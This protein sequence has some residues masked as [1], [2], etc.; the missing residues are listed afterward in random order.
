MKRTGQF[1]VL[2]AAL[3]LQMGFANGAWAVDT[4]DI[5][6][7]R[8]AQARARSL[9]RELIT[10]VLDIQLRQLEENNLQTLP[11]YKDIKEM[12]TNID[13]VEAA[14]MQRVVDALIRVQEQTDP[15]KRLE[16]FNEAREEIRV[17][18]RDLIAERQKLLRRLQVARLAA[19]VRELIRREEGILGST[20]ETTSLPK[21]E[22]ER[23][24]LAT[25]ADQKDMRVLYLELVNTIGDMKNWGGQLT[26]AAIRAEEILDIGRVDERPVE[27]EIN[28][29]IAALE[30]ARVEDA[31]AGEKL[32]IERLERLLEDIEKTQG[33]I[34]ADREEAIKM[35]EE[36]IE[37]QQ[38]LR[39]ETQ[40]SELTDEQIEALSDKQLDVH[41]QIGQIAQSLEEIDA[42]QPLL[43]EAKASALDARDELFEGDQEAADREQG[44]VLGA[45]NEAAEQLEKLI[46]QEEGGKSADAL[47]ED[48]EALQETKAAL[49][50]VARQ[51][52][53]AEQNAAENPAEAKANEE[54]VEQA[55]EALAEE[56]DLPAGVE[57]ALEKRRGSRGGRRRSQ[58]RRL[59]GSCRRT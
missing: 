28:S 53:A 50:E 56:K 4:D 41:K 32:V 21:S 55:L 42:V 18:V 31:I 8:Q 14:K 46:E 7:K 49:E 57:A 23:L 36:L 39:S 37:T 25:A 52:D 17:V 43:D 30:T 24:L 40:N 54:A 34:G 58:R 13:T 48:V 33:L 45:L 29:I 59:A 6:R 3:L 51:Q 38:T 27:A 11:I 19:Q 10:G 47:A 44:E 35:I 5:G 22:G 12:R 16:G 2:I 1:I 15:Q 20:Q 26:V 9:A